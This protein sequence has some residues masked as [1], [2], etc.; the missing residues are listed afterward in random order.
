MA[1]PKEWEDIPEAEN[2]SEEGYRPNWQHQAK[3]RLEPEFEGMTEE[4]IEFL[5]QSGVVEYEETIYEGD[6][7][8]VAQ[9]QLEDAKP[10]DSMVF[11]KS[12]IMQTRFVR[13]LFIRALI[14]GRPVGRVM[15]DCGAMVNVMPTS[16]F[17]KLGKSEDELKLTVTIMTDFTGSG[18]QAKGCLQPNSR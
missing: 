9:L 10:A 2:K 16:F 4:D 18:Q 11:E 13:P 3:L 17:K 5:G 15:V 1:F 6:E 12:S 7:L 14:E 8:T